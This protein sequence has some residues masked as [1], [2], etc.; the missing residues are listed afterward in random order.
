MKNY[1]EN[2]KIYSDIFFFSPLLL[3]RNGINFHIQG[4]SAIRLINFKINS[5]ATSSI[6]IF[7]EAEMKHYGGHLMSF[8]I[9]LGQITKS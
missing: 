2:C 4:F 1:G 6:V 3:Y 5:A 7:T 8:Y 9:N